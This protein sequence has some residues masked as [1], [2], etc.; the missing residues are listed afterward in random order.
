MYFRNKLI[1]SHK[2]EY[3]LLKTWLNMKHFNW[4]AYHSCILLGT[5]IGHANSFL[6][7]QCSRL[8]VW[9]DA[10]AYTLSPPHTC[11]CTRLH[12][13]HAARLHVESSCSHPLCFSRATCS[14][15]W[16]QQ[17]ATPASKRGVGAADAQPIPGGGGGD[18]EAKVRQQK[19]EDRDATPDLL[20]KHPD[21]TL[22][23]YV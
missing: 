6:K 16:L 12:G 11:I 4:H 3:Y 14:S 20:L 1:L 18:T 2:C 15:R 9:S 23:T 8:V 21:A 10:R 17:V 19:S 7:R 13:A 22:A 5:E